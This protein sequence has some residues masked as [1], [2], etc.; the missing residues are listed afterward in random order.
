LLQGDHG[1]GDEDTIEVIRP[2]R[3]M[4]S[5]ELKGFK[6]TTVASPFAMVKPFRCPRSSDL[7]APWCPPLTPPESPQ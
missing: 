1:E 6:E 3:R 2:T 4:Q 7:T 5:C